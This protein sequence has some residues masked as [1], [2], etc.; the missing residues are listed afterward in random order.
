M[1]MPAVPAHTAIARWRST[2]SGN[3]L[4]RMDRV[5]GKTSAAPTPV[6]R[7]ERDQLRRAG[8]QGRAPEATA[9]DGEAGG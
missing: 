3:T 6:E 2:G 4:V 8:G 7:A 9:E 1:P 5:A